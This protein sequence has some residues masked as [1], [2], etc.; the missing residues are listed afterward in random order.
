MRTLATIAGI[1]TPATAFA[2]STGRTDDSGIYV[3]AFLGFCALIIVA[4]ALPAI[5]MLFGIV[6]GVK[7]R[8]EARVSVKS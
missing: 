8:P 1:I 7:A 4:Q 3:W 2:A 6:K 5:L